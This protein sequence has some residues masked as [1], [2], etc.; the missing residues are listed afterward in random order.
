LSSADPQ[1][2]RRRLAGLT[3][4]VT[5]ASRG[6]GLAAAQALHDDGA[7]VVVTARTEA[8]AVA[9]ATSIGGHTLGLAA[10]VAD[11][12]AAQACV[13]LT[14]E[15]FGSVDILVNNAATNVGLGPVLEQTHAQFTKT[16]EVNVWAPIMWCRLVVDAWMRAHGGRIVNTASIGGFAASH[17]IGVYNV[18]KAALIH[19]T[20]QLALEIGPTIRVNAVAPGVVRTRMAEA[21][22][23]DNEDAVADHTLL[24]R[25][26]EPRDIGAAIAFLASDDSAWI[27]GQTMV[28]DGGQ[29][30]CT[31]AM[32]Q[33]SI[34]RAAPA[35]M[36]A[37][38][39]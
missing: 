24:G 21:L 34:H 7:N 14:L 38:L 37:Q 35:V 26:G 11:A 22:W 12:D 28:V 30:I 4:L 17:D 8:G 9:A 39:L 6:I 23:R 5:G 29:M 18:S 32:E 25:I 1:P 31:S 36:P 13:G 3:A 19:L 16:M 27:T 33:P 2:C 10:H 20:R 15:R